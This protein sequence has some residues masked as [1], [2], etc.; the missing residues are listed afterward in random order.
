LSNE[1]SRAFAAGATALGPEDWSG[2][3]NPWLVTVLA[4]YGD[5]PEMVRAMRGT[6]F[7][8]MKREAIENGAADTVAIRWRGLGVN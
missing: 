2:G 6:V 3:P 1:A 8:E 4:P 5:G 7:T